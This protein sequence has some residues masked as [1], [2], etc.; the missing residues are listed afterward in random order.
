M[1]VDINK[2]FP[3]TEKCGDFAISKFSVSSKDIRAMIDGI[4]AGEY[5]KLTCNG[6]VVMSNTP[7]EERTNRRFVVSANGDVLIGGLGIGMI[8]MAIQDEPKVKSITVIEKSQE[9]IELVASKLP[10][11]DKVQIINADV[12]T[13]KPEKGQKFDCIYMD[14]WNWVN[15]DVWEE[16]MKPLKRKYC[17]YMKSKSESPKRFTECWAEWEAKNNRRLY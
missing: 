8:I 7:M 5:V 15:S 17:H 1:Y 11:N 10:F 3:N 9:V 16:E 14:I 13:W 2:Y 4:P 12:F 6:D